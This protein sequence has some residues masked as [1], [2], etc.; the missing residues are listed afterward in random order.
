MRRTRLVENPT[1]IAAAPGTAWNSTPIGKC[2][3]SEHPAATW[4]P[5]VVPLTDRTRTLSIPT[6]RKAF[7][8]CL[9]AGPRHK[10]CMIVRCL[11]ALDRDPGNMIDR[12]PDDIDIFSLAHPIPWQRSP[13]RHGLDGNPRESLG[14]P[15]FRNR[16][17]PP[18][19]TCT[20]CGRRL[21]KD[22]RIGNCPVD[23]RVLELPGPFCFGTPYEPP[24]P[25]SA[26]AVTRVKLT[27][28][29]AV[30]GM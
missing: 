10:D 4:P 12:S 27:L 8:T 16:N 15:P 26:G 29:D 13:W 14:L 2:V 9:A 25:R 21:H 18:E 22:Q 6:P 24:P 30:S 1:G 3:V 17:S 7:E 23:S 20:L 28:A 19:F 5:G 11:C